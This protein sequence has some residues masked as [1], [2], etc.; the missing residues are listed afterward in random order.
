MQAESLGT[1]YLRHELRKQGSQAER[2]AGWVRNGIRELFIE[3]FHTYIVYD[4][5]KLSLFPSDNAL[6]ICLWGIACSS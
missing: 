2:G 3:S 4:Y 6:K 1:A 5:L